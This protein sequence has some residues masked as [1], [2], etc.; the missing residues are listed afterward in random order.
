VI[1]NTNRIDPGQDLM[2]YVNNDWQPPYNLD[3]YVQSIGRR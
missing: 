3:E 2:V 1:K